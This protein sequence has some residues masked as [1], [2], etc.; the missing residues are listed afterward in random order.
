MGALS[1]GGSGR[2]REPECRGGA[3]FFCSIRCKP[4]IDNACGRKGKEMAIKEVGPAE[5]DAMEMA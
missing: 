4:L 1:Q 5:A 3:N 2:K